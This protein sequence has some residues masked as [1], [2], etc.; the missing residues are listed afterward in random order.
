MAR[1]IQPGIIINDRSGLAE[2][3]GTPEQQVVEKARPWEVCMTTN[4]NWGFHRGDRNWKTPRQVVGAV[5][6][7][8][9]RGGN[10]ILNLGPRADGGV[11]PRA[12][13]L[14]EEVGA[15]LSRNG[16]SVYGCGKAPHLSREALDGGYY[17]TTGFWTAGHGKLYY[18]VLRW[19]G[20]S[21]GVRTQGVR[22]L[23]ARSLQTGES[24]SVKSNDGRSTMAGLPRT[25][26]DPFDTVIECEYER[27]DSA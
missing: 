11:P 2:D 14:F 12:R 13:G 9:S 24:F 20:P 18:H 6:H 16:Q 26:I 19:P 25:P 21:L 5:A 1:T 15:W 27:E 7:S 17:C 22:L 4:D 10:L 8:V 3:F 23:A